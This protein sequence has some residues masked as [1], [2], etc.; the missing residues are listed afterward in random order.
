MQ[1]S[2]GA[3]LFE[4]S[5]I[6]AELK[7]TDRPT[8]GCH[9]RLEKRW[10][11]GQT[12]PGE[13][14]EVIES[15]GNIILNG[16]GDVVLER[17]ISKTPTTSSTGALTGAFS[18]DNSCIG[19]SSAAST[20]AYTATT[21]AGSPTYSTMTTGYPAHT[22]GTASSAARQ[23]TWR[24]SFSSSQANHIWNSWTVRNQ[25]TGGGRMLNHRVQNLGTKTS[26][27][28]WALAVTIGLS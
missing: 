25:S 28:A 12:H 22:T 18:S 14:Y 24:A 27:G 11:S 13:L 17:L 10:A 3:S 7:V 19:V 5:A 21:F 8:W 1:R 2:D 4:R 16:G 6:A 20:V 9:V 23:V 26:N 15:R